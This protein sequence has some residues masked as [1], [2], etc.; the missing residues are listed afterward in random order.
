MYKNLAFLIA[1]GFAL[2]SY[3]T[4]EFRVPSEGLVPPATNVTVSGVGVTPI[5]DPGPVAP[6][7]DPTTILLANG[8][9]TWGDGT[10]ASSCKQYLNPPSGKQY[11]GDTGSGVYSILLNGTP[12]DML[13]DMTA[14][15]GGWTL[16]VH[17]VASGVS[18]HSSFTAGSTVN[19]AGAV[20]PI[21]FQLS[22][23]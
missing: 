8:T 22:V 16:A 17:G 23:E 6:V 18:Q 13:C 2:P 20:T 19:L 15:G 7:I 4:F 12:T 11:A 3:A 5:A 9:R 1:C 21:W 10:S 14:D